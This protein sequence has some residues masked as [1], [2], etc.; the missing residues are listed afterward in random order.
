MPTND[1]IGFA[2]NGSANVMS[3]A[4]YAAAVEQGDGVQ[5]G[6]ASSKLA[7]KAWRQGANMAAALGEVIKA[8]GIDALDNG[9]IATLSNNIVSALS[10]FLLP[11]SGGTMTGDIIFNSSLNNIRAADN[12]HSLSFFGGGSAGATN[13]AKAYLN[14]A[15]NTDSGTFIIQAGN[16]SGYKQ[17]YGKPDGAL[18]WDGTDVF[19][20]ENSPVSFSSSTIRNYCM[21]L[22]NG[23]MVQCYDGSL[24]TD[25]NSRVYFIFSEAFKETPFSASFVATSNRSLNVYSTS[26]TQITFR[27]N[28]MSGASV[29]ANVT[30]PMGVILIGRWK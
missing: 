12:A 25:I 2:S 4:D 22:A 13:G 5:P 14:G 29:G 6:M 9:D 16:S 21:K 30:L 23:A 7:N 10:A 26:T 27:V 3:Q 15:D 11:L 1:F 20:V 8:Q 19:T 24:T 17:L 18:T 28:D